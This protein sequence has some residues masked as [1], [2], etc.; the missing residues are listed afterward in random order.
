MQCSVIE[1][2]YICEHNREK[3]LTDVQDTLKN[4]HHNEKYSQLESV[5]AL[6]SEK[7]HTY[8]TLQIHLC[9]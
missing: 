7:Q 2:Y 4:E 1:K 6:N 5:S 9:P 8:A 3:Q